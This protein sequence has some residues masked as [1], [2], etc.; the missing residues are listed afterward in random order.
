MPFKNVSSPRV[1][2]DLGAEV[3]GSAVLTTANLVAMIS[4]DPVRL[5]LQPTS[6][7]S[8]KVVN[9][10]LDGAD[11]VALITKDVAV[12]KSGDDVWALVDLAHSARMDQVARDVRHLRFRP[13]GE[14]ALAVCWDG[15]ATQL[16]LARHEVDGRR[17][18]LRGTVRA[19]DVMAT[20]CAVVV[21][22]AEGGELRF[23]P[24]ATPEPGSSLRVMLPGDAAKHDR[25]RAGRD[26]SAVYKPGSSKVTI[27]Q[28][29][30]QK[31]TAKSIDVGRNVGD[32][33]VAETSLFV[34]FT[35]GRLALF[36]GDVLTRA[37]EG[38]RVE[39]THELALGVR[40]EPRTISITGKGTP[41]LWV[42]T[43]VG[44][45]VSATAMRKQAAVG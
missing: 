37:G 4:T 7:A 44:E 13:T 14:N 12:V 45:V 32:V 30:G 22:G 33:Q 11:E 1:V 26:L 8:G 25:L 39:P 35:D 28:R 10:S 42:G 3:R 31:L 6:G 20:E 5:L 23:H 9:V 17:F 19:A 38:G 34:A 15:T 43:S 21:D 18:A 36:D 29:S 41:T 27:A 40:G 24:G 16:V 2:H